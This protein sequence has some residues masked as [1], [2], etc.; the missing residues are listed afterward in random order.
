ARGACRREGWGRGWAAVRGVGGR[1]PRVIAGG[2]WRG[3]GEG[4]EEDR[5]AGQYQACEPENRLVGRELERR[6]EEALK[7]QRQLEEEYRRWQQ[8]AAARLTAADQ[9]AIRMLASDLPAVWQADTTAAAARPRG[10][11]RVRE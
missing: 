10:A 5:A 6:W 11:R 1:R 9:A 4:R 7:Q 3:E 2:G 8:S